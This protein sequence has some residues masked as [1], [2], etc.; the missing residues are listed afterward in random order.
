MYV[1][2]VCLKYSNQ[3]LSKED[4]VE[5][6]WW[7]KNNSGNRILI[8]IIQFIFL[9]LTM[10]SIGHSQDFFPASHPIFL[11]TSLFFFAIFSMTIL[12]HMLFGL[13][14][15]SWEF[16]CKTIFSNPLS[17]FLS[18]CPIQFH[19]FIVNYCSFVSLK[20]D[21]QEKNFNPERGLN[22]GSPDL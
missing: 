8:W 3:F 13:P 18:L 10:R 16:Q 20:L 7:D 5:V 4:N 6:D 9:H 1:I 12:F 21:F 19:F 14:L 15:L 2:T 22:H 11:V 17:S